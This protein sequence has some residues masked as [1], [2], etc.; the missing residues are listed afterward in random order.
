M[1]TRSWSRCSRCS[2]LRKAWPRDRYAKRR[3]SDATSPCDRRAGGRSYGR[4]GAA[5]NGTCDRSEYRDPSRRSRVLV[6]A[7]SPLD[8]PR[9]AAPKRTDPGTR[10]R[11]PSVTTTQLLPQ[12]TPDPR[13]CGRPHVQRLVVVTDV[14]TPLSSLDD[15]SGT[16]RS[17]TAARVAGS[18]PRRRGAVDCHWDTFIAACRR[19]ACDAGSACWSAPC[20][21]ARVRAT[22]RWSRGT[23]AGL[24]S[25]ER[26][27]SRPGA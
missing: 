26:R 24:P 8:S 14:G 12:G 22:R 13:S 9:S 6:A 23:A 18:R 7:A 1:M 25:L 16:R 15:W 3:L 21:T 5:D 19:R 20:C 10:A 2:Q 27:S 17:R 4:A 11:A